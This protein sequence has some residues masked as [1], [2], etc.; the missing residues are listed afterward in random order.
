[1][2]TIKRFTFLL[3]L[4][5]TGSAFG[6]TN[7]VTLAWIKSPADLGQTNWVYRVYHSTNAA[8]PLNQWSRI[9][10]V[11]GGQTNVVLTVVPGEHFFYLTL[12][13]TSG[14][15]GESNP[16]NVAST[17]AAATIPTGLTIRIGGL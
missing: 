2:N 16:S 11:P 15:W 3:A 10:F 5:L 6:M 8:Q 14:G 17:P 4:L 9:A 13:D 7:Q 1:M 12:D